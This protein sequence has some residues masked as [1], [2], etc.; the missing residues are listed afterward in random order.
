MK[1][2]LTIILFILILFYLSEDDK[3]NIIISNKSYQLFLIFLIIIISYNN[4]NHL[5]LFILIILPILFKSNLKDVFIK[6]YKSKDIYKD[7]NIIVEK[8]KDVIINGFNYKENYNNKLDSTNKVNQ[9]DIHISNH[10]INDDDDEYNNDENINGKKNF[11]E[12]NNDDNY[13]GEHDDDDDD[14]DDENKDIDLDEF[15]NYKKEVTL[16]NKNQYD[17]LKK[18]YNNLIE[19]IDINK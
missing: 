15:N 2:L 18:K 12:N 14:N 9:N 8:F 5:I 13:Y 19:K 7:Y 1:Q 11:N 16:N 10:N 6:K 3:L 17:L 4:L